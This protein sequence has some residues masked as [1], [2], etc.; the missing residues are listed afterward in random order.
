LDASG[1]DVSSGSQ[2]QRSEDELTKAFDHRAPETTGTGLELETFTGQ[3]YSVE[4]P[5]KVETWEFFVVRSKS[6]SM[7]I[8]DEDEKQWDADDIRNLKFPSTN[9]CFE[10]DLEIRWKWFHM[11]AYEDCHLINTYFLNW[12]VASRSYISKEIS[13]TYVPHPDADR[14]GFYFHGED[15]AHWL[16]QDKKNNDVIR[17]KEIMDLTYTEDDP[18]LGCLNLIGKLVDGTEFT[19]PVRSSCWLLRASIDIA[20]DSTKSYPAQ[21]L[22][23]IEAARAGNPRGHKTSSINNAMLDANNQI[24]WKFDK[25]RSKS[26]MIL[27]MG[28]NM[29]YIKS[30]KWSLGKLFLSHTEMCGKFVIE[31]GKTRFTLF[32]SHYC[33]F[34]GRD[35]EIATKDGLRTTYIDNPNS[36]F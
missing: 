30:M 35:I 29:I 24:I 18:E 28:E 31:T 14:S 32:V 19:S 16:L 25:R 15:P 26:R 13:E 12:A 4:N 10:V 11:T 33:E 5:D 22:I 17:V 8:L 27:K 1:E 3:V 2:L 23:E 20:R 34:L 6:R 9:G 7:M 36:K 21:R